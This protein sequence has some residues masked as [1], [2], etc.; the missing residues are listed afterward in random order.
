MR[1]ACNAS[2]IKRK[3]NHFTMSAKKPSTNEEDDDISADDEWDEGEY[4]FMQDLQEAKQKLG[5]PIG[6]ETTQEAEEAAGRLHACLERDAKPIQE[7]LVDDQ[8]PEAH[9]DSH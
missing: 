4:E 5:S 2:V 1:V 7:L 3:N 6:Y 8:E 9:R